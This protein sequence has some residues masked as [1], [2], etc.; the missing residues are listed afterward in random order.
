MQLQIKF[1]ILMGKLFTSLIKTGAFTG[2][3]NNFFL[4]RKPR[5]FPCKQEMKSILILIFILKF[6]SYQRPFKPLIFLFI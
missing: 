3:A 2:S 6:M 5:L 4:E 1:T